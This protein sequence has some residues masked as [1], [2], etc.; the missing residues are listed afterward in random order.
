M[1]VCAIVPT[2]RHWQ[3]L[4]RIV[5]GLRAAGL[6]V[7]IIDDGNDEPAA[8]AIAALDDPQNA[9]AVHRLAV[10]Q[11]KGTA[12]IE[13]FRLAWNAGYSHAVQI[14]ADGQH[15]LAALPA[16]LELAKRHQQALITGQPRYDASIPVGRKIGR[17]VTHVWVWIETLSLQIT[18]SMCGF[19]VYPLAAVQT[20][21]DQED[22][23][24]RMEFDTEIMVRLFWRGTS[25]AHVPVDVVYPADNT[26]NFDLW[27]DNLRISWMH[28][29]L[30]T[31]MLRRLVTRPAGTTS[32]WANLTE[33]GTYWG[34]VFCTMAYRLFGRRACLTVMAPIVLWFFLAGRPQR[35]ASRTFLSRVFGRPATR[36]ECFRHFMSFA[37][38]ALDT[39]IAWTGGISQAAVEVTS[40]G[41]LQSAMNNRRGAVVVVAHLGNVDL[42]RA[43]LDDA[44]RARLTVLVHN[45]HA[46]NYNRILRRFRP[47]AALNLLQVSEIGPATAIDLKERT[48]RGEWIVIA[49]DRTPVGSSGRVSRVPF[50][51]APALFSQG[52]WI[53]A[54]LLDCPIYLLFC[55]KDG[56]NW[57]LTMEPFAERIDLPRR[58]RDR[59]LQDYTARYGARLEDYARQSPFQWYNFFDFWAD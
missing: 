2:Y 23:G 4:P 13:G 14:D 15:D 18:D 48:E 24:R 8:A 22:V 7:Y 54:S 6:A 36:L 29:R 19:R 28:T 9:V 11:G 57:R 59:A 35:E 5:A 52:P 44:T 56:K 26:S 42:A 46:A 50:L 25:V 20:L 49:G 12:V 33:R 1:K 41:V 37:A 39:F 53:L 43:V 27:R 10:N 30:V 34:L 31:G 58:Y 55:L 32:H 51:G 40:P 45:R 17:W 38:R 47:E 16:L 3:A 21:L